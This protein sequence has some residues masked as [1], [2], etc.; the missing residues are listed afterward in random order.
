MDMPAGVPM[1]G[2]IYTSLPT[3]GRTTR[4]SFADIIS[5][6]SESKNLSGGRTAYLDTGS[7]TIV[8]GNP[9]DP[10]GGTA[11][12]PEYGDPPRS[13]QDVWDSLH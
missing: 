7:R 8:V 2:G 6:A 9:N 13:V 11:F 3:W 1:T 12:R 10:D 4:K 5:D